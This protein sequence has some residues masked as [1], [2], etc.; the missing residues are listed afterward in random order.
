MR[1]GLIRKGENNTMLKGNQS[2]NQF[3]NKL[4]YFFFAIVLFDCTFSGFGHWARIGRVSLRMLAAVLAMV[5]S[6][7]LLKTNLK[8]MV[9]DIGIVS[10]FGFM[11]AV[12]YSF[13]VGIINN[14]RLDLI[15][16]DL[17]GFFWFGLIIPAYVSGFSRQRIETLSRVLIVGGIIQAI[18]VNFINFAIIANSSVISHLI[19]LTV[20]FGFG[21]IDHVGGGVYRIFFRSNLYLTVSIIFILRSMI[22]NKSKQSYL[23]G[24][25]AIPI[26]A[27][28]VFIT[29]TRSTY[30]AS[31]VAV[32]CLVC[33]YLRNDRKLLKSIMIVIIISLVT[34]LSYIIL[35]QTMSKRDYFGFFINRL[36][37]NKETVSDE[38]SNSNAFEHYIKATEQSDKLREVTTDDLRGLIRQSPIFGHGLGVTIKSRPGGR[39][40]YFFLDLIAKIGLIGLIFFFIPLVTTVIRLIKNRYSDPFLMSTLIS[41]LFVFFVASFFN[42]Y[43]N[44]ALG[45][46][47]YVFVLGVDRMQY[48]P[49]QFQPKD[50]KK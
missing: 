13:V 35:V 6:L 26:L 4:T 45:I 27:F 50:L 10:I 17:R 14:N 31:F 8:S 49:K 48:Q 7:P 12:F 24:I 33:F 40:E 5:G 2:L 32:F 39:N 1:L 42:P 16:L 29:F 47:F 41:G 25:F 38:R 28:A 30:L 20:K 3:M 23:V 21:W 9:T 18:A 46:T 36:L 37:L 43:M 19:E 44:S 34:S 22:I 11:L 15:I